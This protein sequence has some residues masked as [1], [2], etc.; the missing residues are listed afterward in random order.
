[1]GDFL[2]RLKSRKL[3]QWAV[4]YLAAAWVLLQ[5]LDLASGSYHWPDAVMHIA[6]GVLAVGFV[7][8]RAHP[9]DATIMYNTQR[10]LLGIGDAKE[11]SMLLQR[12]MASGLP[13]ED[14][15]IAQ[16]RQ[17]CAQG[18]NAAAAQ[19]FARSGHATANI[20]THWQA[21]TLLGRDDEAARLLDHLDTPAYL[22]A[23]ASWLIYPQFDVTRHPR[24]QAVLVAQGIH[25]PP[26]M[27]P[28]FACKGTSGM[29]VPHAASS[30]TINRISG[31]TPRSAAS[32]NARHR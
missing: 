27:P 25:R 20:A 19:L 31:N 26:A 9:G 2:Q 22:N 21:L 18:R 32:R 13:A 15:F 7:V 1:M 5:V 11:A 29:D 24:L 30:G 28:P 3:V 17:L 23:L 10:A 8:V 6:F 14:K 4:A 12:I 16:M